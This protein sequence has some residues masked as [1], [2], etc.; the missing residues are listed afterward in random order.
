M[1]AEESTS[2]PMVSRP[3]YVGGL[4]FHLKWDLGWMHDTL[5]YMRLDPIFRKYDHN[6]VT[7]RPL[8]AFSENFLCR[9]RMMRWCMARAHCSIKCPAAIG[10]N[11]PICGSC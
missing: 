8:Y 3:P 1:M 4:G 2:W 11:V 10:I 6:L 7:F 9:C 5:T